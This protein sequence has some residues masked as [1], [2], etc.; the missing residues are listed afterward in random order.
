MPE[1]INPNCSEI[2]KTIIVKNEG[3]LNFPKGTIM[4]NLENKWA[5]NILI[6]SLEVGKEAAV[7][8][9]INNWKKELGKQ[10]A[11]F[12]VCVKNEDNVEE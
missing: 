2:Y 9:R 12:V 10:S 1:I 5:Q 11:K 4:R 3:I 6:P 7:V 8:A